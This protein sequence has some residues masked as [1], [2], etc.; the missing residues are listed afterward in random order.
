MKYLVDFK[1]EFEDMLS[2]NIGI[3][4]YFK[5]MGE[6]GIANFVGC[7]KIVL[8]FLLNIYCNSML[9]PNSDFKTF[10]KCYKFH[11]NPL[12]HILLE[13]FVYAEIRFIQ[14]YIPQMSHEER[15]TG[16]LISELAGS[17]NIVKK[18]FQEMSQELYGKEI[19]LLFHYA[20]MSTKNNEKLTGADFAFIFHVN[21]PD[22]KKITRLAIIQA[23][24]FQSEAEID[25]KQFR[26]LNSYAKKHGFYCFY[27]ID[28]TDNVSP[29]IRH[30]DK[31]VNKNKAIT[32]FVLKRDEI[33]NY[34]KGSIPLSLF[35]LEHMINPEN[36]EIEPVSSIS[37]ARNLISS[38]NRDFRVSKVMIVSVGAL[39]END[40]DI[41]DIKKIFPPNKED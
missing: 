3:S 9:S 25:I 27:D 20:D 38:D 23:K 30:K 17:L 14:N 18:A 19:P 29:L 22:Y 36:T 39:P 4:H 31:I 2:E 7:N 6:N 15:L 16:H 32:K 8:H 10:L 26:V 33:L 41:H 13:A 35:L 37:E 11:R 5:N 12:F 21:L 28:Q 34:S 1:P 40:E 24:K